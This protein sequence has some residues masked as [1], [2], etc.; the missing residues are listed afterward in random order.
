VTWGCD[1]DAVARRAYVAV[2]SLGLLEV[3]DYDSGRIVN[4]RFAGL[5]IRPVAFDPQRRL[6]YAGTFLSGDVIAVDAD[7]LEVVHRWFV[8]RFLRQ[9]EISRDRRSLLATSTLGIV[10]V[11]LPALASHASA[12]D[13][14]SWG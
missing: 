6:I 13:A 8:G 10:R 9:L 11:P 14:S 5:G 1:W 4:W 7:T 3:I 2:A 12:A